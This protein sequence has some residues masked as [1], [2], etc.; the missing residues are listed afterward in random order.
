[1][2]LDLETPTPPP[3]VDPDLLAAREIAA[4]YWRG[5][6]REYAGAVSAGKHDEATSLKVALAAYKAGKE[7][8]R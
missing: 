8:A 6:D 1:V 4:D 2:F 7:A 5:I 3:D